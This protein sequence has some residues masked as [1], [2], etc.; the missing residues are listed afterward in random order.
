MGTGDKRYHRYGCTYAKSN[1]ELRFK[2]PLS[3]Q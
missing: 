3:I 1:V 2:E